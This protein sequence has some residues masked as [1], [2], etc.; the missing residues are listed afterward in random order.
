MA[1]GISTVSHFGPANKAMRPRR[2]RIK[3]E[4]IDFLVFMLIT[5]S[6]ERRPLGLK[7]LDS[8]ALRGAEAPLFHGAPSLGESRLSK[9]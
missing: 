6:C 3:V 8:D 7:P 2:I 5:T 9:P 4:P 1:A